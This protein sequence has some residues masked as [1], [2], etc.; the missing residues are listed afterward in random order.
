MEIMCLTK[1]APQCSRRLS[2]KI[3]QSSLLLL[4]VKV[5]F[6]IFYC[7]DKVVVECWIFQS[8]LFF[9]APWSILMFTNTK[10]QVV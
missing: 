8:V 7:N 9:I 6:N 1:E 2:R 5:C 4:L 10:P 3:H